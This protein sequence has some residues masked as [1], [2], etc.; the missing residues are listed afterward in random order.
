MSTT[1]QQ[2]VIH[3]YRL[4]RPLGKGSYGVVW[5]AVAPGGFSAAIKLI[6]RD[7]SDL[8]ALPELKALQ[9]M[10]SV[11][12]PYLVNVLACWEERDW[13]IIAMEMA[14]GNLRERFDFCRQQQL[15]GVPADELLLYLKESADALD[16]L[17]ALGKLH[18]DIKPEN[19]LLFLGPPP[20]VKIGDC[21]LLR[22][23]DRLSTMRPQGTPQY[24]P[25]E[26]WDCKPCPA[27]DQFSLALSYAEMRQGFRPFGGST[28]YMVEQAVRLHEPDLS[29][30]PEVEAAPLRRALAKSPKDRFPSC[31]DFAEA[32]EWALARRADSFRPTERVGLLKEE[33]P[34]LPL[35]ETQ[36]PSDQGAE[37]VRPE[38]KPKPTP[39]PPPPTPPRAPARPWKPWAAAAAAL[40]LLLAAGG[41]WALNRPAG[42]GPEPKPGPE[43]VDTRP[44]KIDPPK[45]DPPKVDPP[46]ARPVLLRYP[47]EMPVP[48]LPRNFAAAARSEVVGET[49][50]P[51][52]HVRIVRAVGPERV[53][54][55][56]V[57]G[58]VPFYLMETK[59][60]NAL[61]RRF[62]AERPGEV[63]DDWRLGGKADGRDTLDIVARHPVFRV[64]RREA[65]AF[66][67][68]LGG[69]L[70]TAAQLDR[71]AAAW[72][73]GE[74]DDVAVGL[75]RQGPRAVGTSRGDPAD[76]RGNGWEWARN[77]VQGGRLAVLR[78]QSYTAARPAVPGPPADPE[79]V[80][81]QYPDTGSPYT[82][83]RVV[84][85]LAAP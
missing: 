43:I 59:V 32:M 11:N 73:R 4:L 63:G 67:D 80:P 58:P 51:H 7:R 79:L 42:A 70:P 37:T 83:F 85:E 82:G 20:H 36:P 1:T 48:R 72:P 69:R 5:Q 75:R 23:A 21:G 77:L 39:P 15:P 57:P 26:A 62:A 19:L 41:W 3:G 8:I 84:I 46:K 25:P 53:T 38:P 76:L 6:S 60:W 31:R 68:W 22:D 18:R 64:K 61:F 29:G 78:G 24:M 17:H 16:Y 44:P 65:E 12:H 27:S 56:L 74:G 66:A 10:R 40:A 81:T 47:R 9:A 34:S 14:D 30:V 49:G 13:V 71:A 45:V 28:V 52:Y 33:P 50:G 55:R 35:P 54:F 2:R